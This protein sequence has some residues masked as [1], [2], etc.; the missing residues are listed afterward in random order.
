MPVG[1]TEFLFITPLPLRPPAL[2][3]GGAFGFL[4]EGELNGTWASS[5]RLA[6]A[7]CL[8]SFKA[9]WM[10][11]VHFEA[12]CR[13]NPLPLRVLPLGRGRVKKNQGRLGC[14]PPL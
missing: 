14:S 13:F 3:R 4:R 12:G 9:G 11:A 2:R 7:G 1:L 10:A 6:Q 5:P 8:R